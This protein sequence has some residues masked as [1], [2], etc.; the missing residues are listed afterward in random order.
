M[1]SSFKSVSNYVEKVN[2]LCDPGTIKVIVGNKCDLDNNRK[3]KMVDLNDKADE[4]EFDLY[5]ETSAMQ[6][7]RGTIDALFTAVVTKIADIPSDGG[8]RGQKLKR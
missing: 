4:H 6:E 2:Q 8:R 5:F 1:P 7:Y 3:V